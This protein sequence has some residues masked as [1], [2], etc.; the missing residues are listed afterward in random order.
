M[1]KCQYKPKSNGAYLLYSSSSYFKYLIVEFTVKAT[2]RLR[3]TVA[4][5][6]NIPCT[7][8]YTH[9]YIKHLCICI[10]AISRGYLKVIRW[11]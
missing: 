3:P 7:Q 6:K 10:Y 1:K 9:L 4:Q 8:I 5:A 2:T 11:T